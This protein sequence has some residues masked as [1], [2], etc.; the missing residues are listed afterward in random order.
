M[1]NTKREDRKP[2]VEQ[3]AFEKYMVE[4]KSVVKVTSGGR[5]NR[6]RV[7]VVVGD[8][9]TD[10]LA[11]S[12]VRMYDEQMNLVAEN[13]DYGIGMGFDKVSVC[14]VA[15]IIIPILFGSIVRIHATE[16]GRFFILIPFAMASC[17]TQAPTLQV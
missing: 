15:G 7:L 12:F 5:H 4:R 14:L 2:R 9:N 17:L 13:S 16:N 11:K 8:K 3:D 10:T 1:A 6:W